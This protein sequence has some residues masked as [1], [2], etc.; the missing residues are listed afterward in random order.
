MATALRAPS[1]PELLPHRLRWREAIGRGSV[2]APR[3]ERAPAAAADVIVRLDSVESPLMGINALETTRL[4]RAVYRYDFG[5]TGPVRYTNAP[6]PGAPGA[7]GGSSNEARPEPT[8]DLDGE[9]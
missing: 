1:D 9:E 2:V 8:A 5:A 4:G 3:V 7:A 6:P